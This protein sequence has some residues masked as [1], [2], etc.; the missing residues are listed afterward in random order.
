[1]DGAFENK[2]PSP[3]KPG[4]LLRVRDKGEIG[5]QDPAAL[6][7]SC[8]MCISLNPSRSRGRLIQEVSIR[9]TRTGPLP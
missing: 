7:E 9:A 6:T 4:G 1:M 8:T 2:S 3:V 5:G